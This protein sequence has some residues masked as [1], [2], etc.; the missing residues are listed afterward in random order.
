M[1]SIY[2]EHILGLTASE[3]VKPAEPG[4]AASVRRRYQAIIRSGRLTPRTSPKPLGEDGSLRFLDRMAGDQRFVFL[5]YGPRYRDMRTPDTCYGFL[6][7]AQHLIEQHG[8][9]VGPDLLGDYEDLLDR[10]IDEVDAS[11]PPLPMISD[12]ELA[13]FA[14][15][16]GETDPNLLAYVQSAS[17]SRRHDLETAIALGDWSVEGTATVRDRFCTE[18]GAIQARRLSGPAALASLR[19]GLEILIPGQLTLSAAIGRIEA[20]VII[21]GE[22]HALSN[23]PD[24]HSSP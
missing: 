10:I 9:L 16:M 12:G 2:A 17:T 1:T 19:P 4:S 20:G 18:V 24:R 8:A 23:H 5:S 13:E 22:H 21:N 14:A 11:L 6:F 7:G 15:L 3:M